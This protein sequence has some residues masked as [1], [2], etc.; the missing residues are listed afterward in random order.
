MFMK[1]NQRFQSLGTA[2]HEVRVDMGLMAVS[3]LI[4]FFDRKAPP[5]QV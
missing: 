5:N 1:M 3:N 4:A 2:A